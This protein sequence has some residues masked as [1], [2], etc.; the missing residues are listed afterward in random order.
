MLIF[1]VSFQ[2]ERMLLER[3]HI[4][5]GPNDPNAD[6]D[7]NDDSY[8]G[9]DWRQ[10]QSAVERCEYDFIVVRFCVSSQQETQKMRRGHTNPIYTS[11]FVRVMHARR[12]GPSVQALPCRALR[13]G[14]PCRALR[15]GSSVQAPPCRPLRAGTAVQPFRAGTPV[16]APPCSTSV[17]ATPC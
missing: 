4:K 7:G 14:L 9:D 12:A 13:A 8:G 15:S 6:D 2:C 11:R 17:Q 1:S 10:R 3:I 5:S 16:Q